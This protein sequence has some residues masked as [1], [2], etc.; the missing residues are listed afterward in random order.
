MTDRLNDVVSNQYEKWTYPEP[1]QDIGEWLVD[2]WQ[3]FDPS[4]AY[5]QFWP[6]REYKP[7]LDI[8]IAGCGSNQ[9]AIIAY[10]NR[11]ARVVAIDVSQ[12]SLDHEQYLKDRHGLSNLELH[13]LPIEEVS[14][15]G[16]DF[17]L[18]MSTGVLHHLAD[19]PLGMKALADCLRPG[20][21]VG[22]MLYARY[23]RIGVELM[24]SVFRDLGLR[25]DEDGIRVVNETISMLDPNHPFLVYRDAAPDLYYDAGLVDTCLHGRDRS[26]TTE[27]CIDLLGSA[28]LVFQ[29]WFHNAPYYPHDINSLS[30]PATEFY[31]I[32]SALPERKMWSLL[33]KMRTSNSCHFF[34]AAH[35][36]RPKSSYLIDF[37]SPEALDY[38][39]R[40]RLSCGLS[41]AELHRPHWDMTLNAAELPYVQHINGQR[42]I[43]EIAAAVGRNETDSFKLGLYENF[44][45]GLFQSLWRLDFIEMSLEAVRRS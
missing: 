3:W 19:P 24:Q 39:P 44:G 4:H 38:V 17:D 14:T 1:I 26:F 13:R 36:D 30:S 35:P 23:G 12:R 5:L 8:L 37:S 22:L 43:R 29:R 21:A 9:A 10:N 28:G 11:A 16:L 15:L 20:G 25:Q 45:R 27:D 41:G 2:G 31:E 32:M 42:T 40:M 6:D 18:I 34:V 7:D 33:E